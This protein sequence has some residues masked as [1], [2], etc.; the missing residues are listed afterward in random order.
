MIAIQV[1]ANHIYGSL[2]GGGDRVFIELCKCWQKQGVKIDVLCPK[3]GPA[4]CEGYGLNANYTVVSGSLIEKSS[5]VF[6]IPLIFLM[7][8]IKA[9]KWRP[10]RAK[11]TII[12]TPG[13][14][15]CNVIPAFLSRIFR[16]ETVW[17]AHV[18]FVI[19]SP[20]FRRLSFIMDTLSFSLQR[21]SF[22][23]MKHFADLIIVLNST[24]ERQLVEYGIP[25]EKIYKSSGGVDTV[26]LDATR[27]EANRRYDGCYVGRIHPGKGVLDLADIWKGVT[28]KKSDAR[29]AIIGTGSPFYT[30]MFVDDLKSKKVE[31]NVD[32]FGFRPSPFGIMKSSKLLLYP[33]YEAGYGWGL[34]ICEALACGLPAVAYDMPVYREAYS[35]G[36]ILVKT[37]DTSAFAKEVVDLLQNENKRK[38]LG[39][40]GKRCVQKY[41]WMQVADDLLAVFKHI[42]RSEMSLQD[43]RA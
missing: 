41:D 1:L 10:C 17:V 31:A 42:K 35:D 40:R 32:M 11:T 27:P 7:R 36:V 23:L 24:T 15:F 8:S 5:S 3:E 18:F 19:P 9:L 37:G 30:K 14:F 43:A 20:F 6:A 28:E 2:L 29:L 12:Y 4:L 21:L 13:D 34:S 22:S 25:K 33:D 26:E 16:H 39:Q 38:V